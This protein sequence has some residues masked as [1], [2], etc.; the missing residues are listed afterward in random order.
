MTIW[1]IP[2][3]ETMAHPQHGTA[4]MGDYRTHSFFATK[5]GIDMQISNSHGTY[6]VEGKQAIRMDMRGAMV[7]IRPK[8]FG[9]LHTID[10][11]A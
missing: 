1:G 8:A 7:H 5:R 10:L 6:F 2:V 11:N 9:D 3:T 4:I